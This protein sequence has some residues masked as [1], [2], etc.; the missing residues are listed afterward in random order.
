[1]IHDTGAW[2]HRRSTLSR[3]VCRTLDFSV[4]FVRC[5]AS[6]RQSG[7]RPRRAERNWAAQGG[8]AGR[9]RPELPRRP[10]KWR[11]KPEDS[12]PYPMRG[13][14]KCDEN[15][16]VLIPRNTYLG[17]GRGN[18]IIINGSM[19]FRVQILWLIKNNHISHSLLHAYYG[20]VKQFF[21]NT[22]RIRRF[23]H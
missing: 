8:R 9:G 21:F 20:H 19:Y 15:E 18:N 12:Y 7:Q 3:Q 2:S 14:R 1:M 5:R 13:G 10:E 11:G 6:V 4:R 17:E 22:Y 16:W 23:L